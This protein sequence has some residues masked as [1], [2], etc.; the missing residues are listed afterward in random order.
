MMTELTAESTI[1]ETE[2]LTKHFGALTAVSGVNL[3]VG[4]GVHSI[5]GPNGAGKTTLFNL[6]SGFLKP[7]K[8]QI[9]YMGKQ[10]A[11]LPPYRISQMGIGRSFQITSIFPALPVRENIRIA[12]QSRRRFRYNFL[13]SCDSLEGVSAATDTVLEQVG[14][15][16]W[17][18]MPARNLPYGLQRC[19]D[20]GISLATNPLLILLDEPTSGMGSED[21]QRVLALIRQISQRLPVVLIEHN[22]D[23]VLT[24][25]D[26][27]TVLYQ[28]ML[29]AE[30][31]PSEIRSHEKVQEAYLGGY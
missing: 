27:I 2:E 26:K 8:G 17:A 4:A 19:L 10:I 20:I 7:D 1:L 16:Q 15:D 13:M 6:L 11:G 24:I 3:R 29:L 28:G 30:G 5:I 22:I 25:S 18:D 23:V 9:L 14:L 21:T 31:T 12:A